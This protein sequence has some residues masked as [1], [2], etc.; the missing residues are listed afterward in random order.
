[1][2][3]C[4]GLQSADY[5]LS[6]CFIGEVDMPYWGLLQDLWYAQ[7]LGVLTFFTGP[8]EQTENR[9]RMI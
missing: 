6:R 5:D 7:Q 1:M 4:R 9:R 2:G 3:I 8:I